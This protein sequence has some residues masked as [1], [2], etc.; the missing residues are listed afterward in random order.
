[1]RVARIRTVWD[2]VL[3]LGQQEQFPERAGRQVRSLGEE[4]D[5][6]EPGADDASG[7]CTPDPGRRTEERHLRA[8]VAPADENPHAETVRPLDECP[9]VAGRA[10]SQ[11]FVGHPRGTL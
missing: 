1:M 8:R 7:P 2:R 4:Q 9:S 3:L 10:Q 11:A 6:V 5:L